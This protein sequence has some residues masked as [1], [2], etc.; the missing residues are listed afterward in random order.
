MSVID[1]IYQNGVFKPL[2][3][4]QLTENQHVRLHV[5]PIAG[6]TARS[7]LQS[8]EEL[9]NS[10]ISHHGGKPLPDSASD[11]AADRMRDA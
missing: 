2:A 5:E 1:A 7:W 4:V 11:I 9:H 6:A 8:V 3:T 10:I